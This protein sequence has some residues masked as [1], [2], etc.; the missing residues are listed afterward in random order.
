[1]IFQEGT[2]YFFILANPD[3]VV[4]LKAKADLFYDFNTTDIEELPHLFASFGLIP[5]FLY[6]V[7]YNRNSY[8]SRSMRSKA[9]LRYENGTIHS[10]SERFPE[11]TFEIVEGS[12]YPV[13]QNPH[14]PL[15]KIPFSISREENEL[16]TLGTSRNGEFKLFRQRRNK[17]VST[18]YLSLK[19]IVNPELSEADVEKKIE[20]L[21]F[22]AK[23]KNFLFRLV[24]ILYSG[25]A[26]EEQTIVSNLFSHEPEFAVFLRDKIFQIEIL[27]LIHG[28]F[29]NRILISMDER[30]VRYS[31]ARLSPPVRSMIENNISKNK[32]KSVLAS[33]IKKP[34]SGE[35]LEET[36]EREIYRNFSRKIYYEDGIFSIYRE[37]EREIKTDP[38][39]A[40]EVRFR[41]VSNP[42]KFNFQ[43]SGKNSIELYAVTERMILFRV[44]E[45]IEILRF[46]TLI[47]KRER[48]EQF[49]LK[50]PPGRIL[51]IP[52][53]P[54]FRLVCGAGV[55][56][57]KKTFECCVLS[58]DY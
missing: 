5:R 2:N 48:D 19:D 14:R 44:S 27:P 15:G 49:F 53:Y 54:T 38:N 18:R 50:I 40:Q 4:R 13:K 3:S 8:P 36:I 37:N 58:F 46:D 41:S 33:P 17:T 56:T 11:T 45:W 52:Y 20:S 29:L 31:L 24:K 35:S 51:E 21:Y 28:P 1:M 25:T 10:P 34:E 7:E 22:D 32:L 6:S 47:S 9:Y 12:R 16:T 23:G 30:I 57:E 42:D 26:S 55:T 39:T 43:I